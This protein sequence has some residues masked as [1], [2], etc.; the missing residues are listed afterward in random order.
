MGNAPI[1]A[2]LKNIFKKKKDFTRFIKGKISVSKK[3]QLEFE[4]LKGQ[5]SFKIKPL[6]KSNVWG[7]FNNGQATFK[8]GDLI[9]CYTTFGVNFL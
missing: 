9:D 1:R 4:V 7:L 2:K 5:E 3:G 8:K 6:A